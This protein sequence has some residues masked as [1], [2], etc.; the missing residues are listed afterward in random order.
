LWKNLMLRKV[1][2]ILGKRSWIDHKI[3]SLR[4]CVLKFPTWELIFSLW[5]TEN[6]KKDLQILIMSSRLFRSANE[7][8]D[9]RTLIRCVYGCLSLSRFLIATRAKCQPPHSFVGHFQ[10]N[11]PRIRHAWCR[12][13][14]P[15]RAMRKF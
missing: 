15:F 3:L 6:L 9:E 5:L 14:M 11:F 12:P 7:T 13:K 10:W 2:L 8:R 4:K 1:A